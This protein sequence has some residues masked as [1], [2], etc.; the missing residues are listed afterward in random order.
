MIFIRHSIVVIITV[1]LHVAKTPESFGFL[2]KQQ[3]SKFEYEF[4]KIID[5]LI[6]IV[7]V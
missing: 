3:K 2:Q 4:G 7:Y 1:Q 5:L 6:F